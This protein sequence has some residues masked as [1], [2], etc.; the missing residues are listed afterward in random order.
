MRPRHAGPIALPVVVTLLALLTGACGIPDATG[1]S[2]V[3]AGPSTG[4]SS[5]DDS[6]VTEVAREDVLTDRVQFVANYLKAG[7]GDVDSAA[8]RLRK[9]M[10]PDAAR[11]FKPTGTDLRVIRLVEAP[12]NTPGQDLVKL[13]YEPVGTLDKFGL[14]EPATESR[15]DTYE[16]RVG[17]L[18]GRSGLFVTE[19]P[20]ALLISDDALDQFYEQKTIY[21][22]NT[23][24]TALVPDVRYMPRSTPAEQRPNT[25]M[26]WLLNGPAPWLSVADLDE[27]TAVVGKVPAADN[28]RLQIPLQALPADDAAQALDRLRRQLQWSL[29]P[30]LPG[31]LDLKIGHADAHTYTGDDYLADN[32]A[33][34]LVEDPERFVV[35]GG[36]IRRISGSPGSVEPVPVLKSDENRDVVSAALSTSKT[37]AFA[38][39]VTDGGRQALRVAS[40]ELGQQAPL[41]PITGLPGPLG[42]PAWAVTADGSAGGAIGLITANGRLYSFPAGRGAARQIPW[43]GQGTRITSVAVAPDGRRVALVVDGKLYRAALST[44]G[45]TPVLGTPQQLRPADLAS[46]TAVDF[47]SEG[48]LTVAGVRAED[49]RVTIVDVSIDGALQSPRLSDLGDKPV[50]ALSVYPANPQDASPLSGR[51]FSRAVCYSAEGKAWEAL[52]TPDQI[53]ADKLA[54]PAGNQPPG[55]VPTAPFY[56]E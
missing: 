34:R 9:F 40:G 26:T 30:L 49:R 39:V 33:A 36:R 14:L 19:A 2:E 32:P 10:S 47:N 51:S 52:S 22:W 28:N 37:H 46:V 48:W 21:F 8:V 53:G 44:G 35:Y 23:E 38:A 24:Y 50:T 1:V 5:G 11:L 43:T 6:A 16:I 15:R 29:R 13:T 18:P 55:T 7:A 20:P 12:L 42:Q 45:D 4:I 27:G 56:L 3:G 25:I 54:G 41:Q 31:E 17:N